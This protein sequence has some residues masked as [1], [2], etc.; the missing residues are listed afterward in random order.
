M[1]ERREFLLRVRID[2][3]ALDNWIAAGWLA[4]HAPAGDFSELDLARARLIRDL[5]EAMG[6]NEEGVSVALGLV[7]QVHGLRRALA[8]LAETVQRLPEPLRQ[9]ALAA[10]RAADPG[11]DQDRAGP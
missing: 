2:A 8:R 11:L 9:D 5:R 1:V 3:G 10:L 6:V 4:P 7:D